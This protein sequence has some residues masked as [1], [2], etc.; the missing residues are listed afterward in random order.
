LQGCDLDLGGDVVVTSD[1]SNC[2]IESEIATRGLPEI[3]E[4]SEETSEY[5]LDGDMAVSFPDDESLAIIGE[6]MTSDEN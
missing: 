2:S 4:V 5:T 1:D 3:S 6:T